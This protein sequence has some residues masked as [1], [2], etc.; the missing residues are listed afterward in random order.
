M[1]VIR[2]A[3]AHRFTKLARRRLPLFFSVTGQTEFVSCAR[4]L[5]T[6]GAGRRIE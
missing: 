4:G 3:L 6:L 2:P 5:H 1:E